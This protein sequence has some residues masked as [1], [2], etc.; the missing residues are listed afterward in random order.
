[1]SSISQGIL[2]ILRKHQWVHWLT[3]EGIIFL[4]VWESP[5]QLAV[6]GDVGK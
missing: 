1:M 6:T 3:V 5:R 2:E 4:M